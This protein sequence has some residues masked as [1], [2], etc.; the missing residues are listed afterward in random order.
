MTARQNQRLEP[1]T[2]KF[3]VEDDEQDDGINLSDH[4]DVQ[5]KQK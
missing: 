2:Q 1:L 3:L 5:T 4:N